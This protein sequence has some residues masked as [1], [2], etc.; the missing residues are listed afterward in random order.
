MGF[1]TWFLCLVT[2]TALSLVPGPAVLFVV[3]QYVGAAYLVWLGI[4]A[5]R[6]A[7]APVADVRKGLG[8]VP[9]R[10]CGPGIACLTPLWRA[11]TPSF[12]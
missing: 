3:F 4:V 2:E 7:S 10:V 5:L 1:A 11:V 12:P 8:R 6:A 9:A